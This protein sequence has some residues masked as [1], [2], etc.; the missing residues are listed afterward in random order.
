M[1][2]YPTARQT[3]LAFNIFEKCNVG[4][5]FEIHS[6]LS[7]AA[8]T[9]ISNDFKNASSAILC[10]SDVSARGMDFPGYVKSE[11]SNDI[12]DK[13]LFTVLDLSSKYICR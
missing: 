3:G 5:V 12:S 4:K 10:S 8:R 11:Y 1:L 6:R 2:F 9:R 7:Q 13:G